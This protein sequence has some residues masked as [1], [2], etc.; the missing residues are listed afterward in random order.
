MTLALQI[1]DLRFGYPG[2]ANCLNIDAFQVAAGERIFLYGPSGSG[3]STLLGLIGGVLQVRHGNLILLG[4]DL[5]TMH[6]AMRDRMR[7]DHIGFIFQ[8]FN[9]IPYLSVIENV[10][11]PC[12]F[13][14]RRRQLL[15]SGGTSPRIEARRLLARLHLDGIEHTPVTRLSVGQQQR[16][17][18]ARALIGK[19]EII[20]A[21]EPT[22]SLDADRQSDFLEL[23]LGECS[24]NDS[25]LIF[26]SHDR[27]LATHFHREVALPSI[28]HAVLNEAT[29]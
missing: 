16:V 29:S 24:A 10:L 23:L 21:D 3:K 19:P 5:S 26:V 22:S 20:I 11:L 18:A 15:R 13:S 6:S 25:A 14:G 17:A 28:N 8:Q 7:A 4:Q 27:R 12:R 1:N 2:E 9:L